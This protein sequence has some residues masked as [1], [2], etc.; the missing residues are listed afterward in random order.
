MRFAGDRHGCE[1]IPL[2]VSLVMAALYFSTAD[3]CFTGSFSSHTFSSKSL[4]AKNWSAI[5]MW[6]LITAAVSLPSS[7]PTLSAHFSW[8]PVCGTQPA[9]SPEASISM[10]PIVE[11]Q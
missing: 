2:V 6:H 3:L 7:L 5:L 10:A 9:S 1:Q 11:S 8:S 4:P